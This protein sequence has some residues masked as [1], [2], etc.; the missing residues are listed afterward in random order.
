MDGTVFLFPGQ[1]SQ[2]VGMGKSF[3]DAHA[4]VRELFEEASD[5]VGEDLAGLCFDGP[6]D[7]LVQTVNAQPSITLVD[8][9]CFRVLEHEGI[10]PT[11]VAGHSLG[12]YAALHAAGVLSFGDIMRLV[13][14]RGAAM[15]DAADRNPGG[16]VAVFGLDLDTLAAVCADVEELGSVEIANHNS[17]TQV[18]LTGERE[19]LKEAS[20]LAK[21]AGAKLVIP[22]K[23]SGAWHS[24]FMAPAQ[25]IMRTALEACEIAAPA[26]PVIANT[27]GQ[28]HG[29]GETVDLLVEQLVNPVQWARSMHRLIEW[30][31][32]DF[33][34]VGPGKVL[35]GL[36]RDIDREVKATNVQDAETLAKF[37]E[38]LG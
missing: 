1:G 12:E 35:T 6:A 30:G 4:F 38:A 26:I 18:A 15:Q 21:E 22:L 2:Y 23:V 10:E 32:R 36:L 31:A 20:R 25:P 29:T 34:E 7:V 14:A 13:R 28:P 19:A 37:K 3:Y 24:R 5:I 11:A 17:N 33:V 9:A 16:M 27:T 8:V